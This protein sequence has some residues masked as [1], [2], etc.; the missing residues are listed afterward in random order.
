MYIDKVKIFAKAGN[1]GDGAVSFHREKYVPNGGPDGGDGGNGGSVIFKVDTSKNTLLDFKFQKHFRAGNGENG[2]ASNCKGKTSDDLYVLVPRGTIIRDSETGRI[3]AD[4]FHNDEEKVVL[5]GG[6]GGKGNA[7]FANAQRKTP[8]FSQ[9]GET[10]VEREIVLE[11]KT[12]ADVGLVGFPNVGKSTLLSMITAARPKIANYHFTTLS[13]NLG[14]LNRYEETAVIADIPGLVEGASEGIGL[15]HSFLR[16]VERV[17]L[18]VHLVDISAIEGRDPFED[19]KTINRELENYSFSLLDVPQIVCVNKCDLVTDD[20][21]ITAFE[22]KIG[23]RV[24]RMSAVIGEGMD[25]LVDRI[26]EELAKLPP[27][28]PM[29]FEEY[30]YEKKDSSSYEINL[31]EN[32]EYILTG[33]FVDMLCKNI[34]LSD[35]ESFNYFQKLLKDNGIIKDLRKKGAK[36]GDTI[37]IADM[38]FDFVE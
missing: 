12:I 2:S 9:R 36:D 28:A 8:G 7:H 3:I 22:E 13:P 26:F 23:Q 18:I 16:H 21:A 4:M 29:E 31:G 34:V 6:N 20:S 19:F 11:L 15:G 24:V 10:T 14:V 33:G 1:G 38:E 27:P 37:C 35:P 32:G 17:R 5:V 30:T 25:V